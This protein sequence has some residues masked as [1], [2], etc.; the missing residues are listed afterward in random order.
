MEPRER[1]VSVADEFLDEV[2]PEELDWQRLVRRYPKSS[3]AVAALG[4]YL[5]ARS[6]GPALL[7]ALGSFAASRVT[8]QVGELLGEDLA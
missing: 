7:A 8:A 4:G 3:L 6:R 2:L 5:L 1:S